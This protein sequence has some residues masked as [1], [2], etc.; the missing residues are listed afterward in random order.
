MSAKSLRRKNLCSF[1]LKFTFL[2]RFEKQNDENLN[3]N[4]KQSFIIEK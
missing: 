2:E 4:I 1:Q 3:L